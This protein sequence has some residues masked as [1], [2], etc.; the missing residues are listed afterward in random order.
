M[1]ETF[2]IDLLRT[3]LETRQTSLSNLEIVISAT[4]NKMTTT[5][6]KRDYVYLKAELDKYETRR[7]EL[8]GE[9][10][11]LR[12]AIKRLERSE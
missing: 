11:A 4:R 8:R 9:V 6:N 5:T 10:S 1:T 7:R 12:Q 2:V 3:E